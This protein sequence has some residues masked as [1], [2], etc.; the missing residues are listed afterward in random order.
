MR[1]VLCLIIAAALM[2]TAFAGCDFK[3]TGRVDPAPI[4]YAT[5]PPLPENYDTSA[6]Q[7][8]HVS[9]DVSYLISDEFSSSRTAGMISDT[10]REQYSRFAIELLKQCSLQNAKDGGSKNGTLVSPLSVLKTKRNS[11]F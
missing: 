3:R 2:L 8:D 1:R 6:A 10:F 11:N 5:Q 9:G 4:E 7:E